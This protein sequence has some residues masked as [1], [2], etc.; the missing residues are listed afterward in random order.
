[1]YEKMKK[2]YPSTYLYLPWSKSFYAG[3]QSN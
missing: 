1:M 3:T 2:I